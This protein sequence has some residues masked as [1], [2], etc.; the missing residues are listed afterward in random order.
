MLTDRILPREE[1]SKLRDSSLGPFLD[2]FP[3][4]VTILVVEDAAGVIVGHVAV[5]PVY[6]VEEAWIAEPHRGIGVVARRLWTAI[7]RTLRARGCEAAVMATA[8]RAVGEMLAKRGTKIPLEEYS[9]WV[10]H[11]RIS[12][13]A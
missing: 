4:S 5:C 2:R 7:G 13:A 12:S 10:P 3:S 11:S 8:D 1:W 6:H 9:V